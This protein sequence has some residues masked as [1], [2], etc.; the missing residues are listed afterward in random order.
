MV[1]IL[2]CLDPHPAR[3]NRKHYRCTR[4]YFQAG[5]SAAGRSDWHDR[6]VSKVTSMRDAV[7]ELVRDGAPVEIEAFTR[8]ISSAAGHEIIRQRK[9]NLT[10]ARL[11]PDVIYHQMIA[12][13][14]ARKLGF[15]WLR[16]T[17]ARGP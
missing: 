10:L 17:G 12:G 6:L 2:L 11:T 9:R 8:L 16:D 13:G 3:C 7:A 15:S 5:G 1:Q 4:N 14:V